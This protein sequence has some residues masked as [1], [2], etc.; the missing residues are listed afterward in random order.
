MAPL[1][2]TWRGPAGL[3]TGRN[4]IIQ[5][6]FA[7]LFEGNLVQ[8]DAT[9]SDAETGETL[10]VGAGLIALDRSGRIVEGLYAKRIGLSLMHET[11]DDPE[12]VAISGDLPG[13]L[14]MGVSFRVE[15]GEMLFT[16]Q[17]KSGAVGMGAPR[18]VARLKRVGGAP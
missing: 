17:V 7:P 10:S 15:E 11:P 13:G 3:E 1:L 9:T 18:T 2:G 8:L 6:R 12:V 14:S 4:G 16:S 5:M